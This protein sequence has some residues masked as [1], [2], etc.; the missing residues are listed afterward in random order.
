MAYAKD[1]I[2]WKF[3]MY[4]KMWY[5]FVDIFLF[6]CGIISIWSVSLIPCMQHND[7]CYY[8][9]LVWKCVKTKALKLWQ[10]LL[11]FS[12]GI[13]SIWS[14]SLIPCIQHHDHYY[15]FLSF[16]LWCQIE[17]RLKCK[18]ISSTKLYLTLSNEPL[19]KTSSHK[20]R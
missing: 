8:F 15:C 17:L 18:H 14:I 13:I 3:Q 20:I 10:I 7:P 19:K 11:L 16:L 1:A 12:C 5:I 6:S 9:S 4:F 2:H